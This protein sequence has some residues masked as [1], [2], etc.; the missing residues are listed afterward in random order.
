ML[1]T[2]MEWHGVASVGAICGTHHN[3][4]TALSS[5]G[6][7]RYLRLSPGQ[8]GGLCPCPGSASYNPPVSSLSLACLP[9]RLD[10]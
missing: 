3:M 5:V 9:A 7:R 10:T 1:G 2:R 4:S 6:T 8:G